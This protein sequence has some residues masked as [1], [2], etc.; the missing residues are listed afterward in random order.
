MPASLQAHTSSVRELGYLPI[1]QMKKLSLKKMVSLARGFAACK[2]GN[3]TS[4]PRQSIAS[5]RAA[6]FRNELAIRTRCSGSVDCVA[7]SRL[8][9]P[10]RFSNWGCLWLE[11]EK[12]RASASL[13]VI[14]SQ[15][16]QLDVN[17]IT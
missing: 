11:S 7:W 3:P 16:S 6:D 4:I 10:A 17:D 9:T 1:S 14:Y 12:P 8:C 13:K 5:Y 15:A 2:Q